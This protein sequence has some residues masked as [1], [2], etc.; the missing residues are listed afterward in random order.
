MRPPGAGWSAAEL[1]NI[2]G[3]SVVKVPSWVQPRL[4]EYYMYF[5]NHD[6]EFIRL[7]YADSP[8]GP[9]TVHGVPALRN[10]AA[11]TAGSHIA[12]PDVHVDEDARQILMSYHGGAR[13]STSWATSADGLVFSPNV[14]RTFGKSYLRMLPYTAIPGFGWIGVTRDKGGMALCKTRTFG[15]PCEPDAAVRVATEGGLTP[16]SVG[17]GG[18]G[19]GVGVPNSCVGP[20]ARH[21]A[22]RIRGSLLDIYYSSVGDMPERIKMITVDLAEYGRMGAAAPSGGGAAAAAAAVVLHVPGY[23]EVLQPEHLSE[24]SDLVVARSVCGASTGRVRQLRDPHVFA[25]GESLFLFYAGAGETN[26]GVAVLHQ[27]A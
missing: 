17:G 20:R 3:P 16:N 11:F 8:L 6:G 5:A 12:S 7:A 21:S 2:N 14:D 1:A 13:H 18:W 23:T 9:W 25:D 10:R 15:E 27:P 19:L 4:G 26:I 22:L 24:G